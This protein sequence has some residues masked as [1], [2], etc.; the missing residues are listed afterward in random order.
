MPR[1]TVQHEIEYMRDFMAA[2]K[3]RWASNRQEN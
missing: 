1:A 3:I 2:P